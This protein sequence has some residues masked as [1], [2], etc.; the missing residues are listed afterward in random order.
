MTVYFNQMSL[1]PA[2]AGSEA[3]EQPEERLEKRPFRSQKQAANEMKRRKKQRQQ[4]VR[5]Y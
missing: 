3:T 5:A 2:V 1:Q 4:R